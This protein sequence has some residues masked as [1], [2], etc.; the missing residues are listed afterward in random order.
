MQHSFEYSDSTTPLDNF[1]ERNNQLLLYDSSVGGN[2]SRT[3]R[4]DDVYQV[5][6]NGTFVTQAKFDLLKG[7]AIGDTV[8]I[9]MH[10]NQGV[11]V[12]R[13]GTIHNDGRLVELTG[14]SD[15]YE[16]NIKSITMP[17][18]ERVDGN[19]SYGI[20]NKSVWSVRPGINKI[21]FDTVSGNSNKALQ[22]FI[23]AQGF[24][25]G[26]SNELG[27]TDNN[28]GDDYGFIKFNFY[29]K[30]LEHI[31]LETLMLDPNTPG[32]D[33]CGRFLGSYVT[34]TEFATDQFPIY[35]N[36]QVWFGSANIE[37]TLDLD[38]FWSE[39]DLG[40]G[41]VGRD[42][43]DIMSGEFVDDP[44]CL[45]RQYTA[46]CDLQIHSDSN[47]WSYYRFQSDTSGTGG[48]TLPST[49]TTKSYSQAIVNQKIQYSGSVTKQTDFLIQSSSDYQGIVNNYSYTTKKFKVSTSDRASM[50]RTVSMSY[51]SKN[52]LHIR[53]Y[54]EKNKELT[55]VSFDGTEELTGELETVTMTK[56]VGIRAKAFY[57]TLYG[58][59]STPE[60]LEIF[61]V[62]VAY[63]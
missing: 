27:Y 40:Y 48:G 31:G 44:F 12:E 46:D 38:H 6:V 61:K 11:K 1:D 3:Q 23:D 36:V 49:I 2:Q 30:S 14:S 7:A 16:Y 60:T 53:F 34:N 43:P 33:K 13:T 24:R 18:D 25:T 59:G 26:G 20:T 54:D 8:N 47:P 10:I 52:P 58:I 39:N 42:N 41:S 57:M 62:S 4:F 37:Y 29:N 9:T 15:I 21:I 63:G 19:K 56:V 51:R 5:E 35:T 22:I 32:Y 17:N 55:T 50:V 28:F 45:D